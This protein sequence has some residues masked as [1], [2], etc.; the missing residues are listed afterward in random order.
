MTW[1][2]TRADTLREGDQVLYGTTK[3]VESVAGNEASIG[4]VFVGQWPAVEFKRGD[5]VWREEA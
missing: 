3:T 5:V 4:V 2:Q 1:T